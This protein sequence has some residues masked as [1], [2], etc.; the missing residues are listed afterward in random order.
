M[1][2]IPRTFASKRACGPSQM[3][4]MSSAVVKRT[5]ATVMV[6]LSLTHGAASSEQKVSFAK[7]L[8]NADR[9]CLAEM[10]RAGHWRITPQ[11]HQDMISAAVVGRV[12]L[13]EN[14]PKEYIFVV[15]DFASCGT[16]GCSM[17]IGKKD[18]GGKCH[19]IYS[20]SGF[21]S[22]IGVLRK[23]DHGY[24]QLHTPCELRFDGLE[25]RQLHEEC[26]SI[27]VQH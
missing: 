25:Y 15:T 2:V 6:L 24:R 18:R 1:T 21:T 26:P 22:A 13:K 10:L 5:A 7:S 16:A 3:Y 12:H 9:R 11:F 27:D 4:L 20:G 23:R 8:T 14:G 19:E 17:L